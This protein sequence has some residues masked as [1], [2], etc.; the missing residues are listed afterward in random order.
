MDAL[1]TPSFQS[2]QR[3]MARHLRDPRGTPRPAGVSARRMR[4]Y[5]E[6][7]FNNVSGFLDRCFPVSLAVLGERRWRRLARQFW[8][9]AAMSSPLHRDIP[10]AFVAWLDLGCA[11]MPAWLP[12]LARYEWAELA[13]DVMA[14]AVPPHDALGDLR[15]APVLL[16]PAH[17]HL[18][19]DWPVHRIGI[20][21]RPR[22]PQ[23]TR[24]LVYRDAHD[25]VCFMHLNE[26]TSRLLELLAPGG[27]NA[28]QL[29]LQL[30]A[31]WGHA[32]PQALL[33][34]VLALLEQL[35]GQG[36][37]LGTRR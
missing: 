6:L 11:P 1:P 17:L 36:V 30:A 31:E 9:D 26:Q 23:S 32:Q 37:V 21:W 19:M 16:N 13:V 8:R 7:L 24:L 25:K 33:A 10:E 3:A 28:E 5:Q 15:A 29:A 2:F 4:V 34:H 35:R 18:K 27:L 20:T 22:K 14:P 12:A